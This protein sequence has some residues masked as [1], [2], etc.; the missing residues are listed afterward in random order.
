M[1]T[2]S[3]L[4]TINPK[5]P[6]INKKEP[7]R[8]INQDLTSC[9]FSAMFIG[10]KNS[11]KTYGLCAWIRNYESQ[12]IINSEG[13]SVPI[14]IILF[15]PTAQSQANP[16]YKTLKNLDEE[17]IILQYT[18]AELDSKLESI[19]KDKEDIEDYTLYLK[20]WK[21]FLK[22]DE[23]VNLLTPEELLILSKFDFT[24]PKYLNKPKYYPVAPVVFIILDDLIGSNDCFK[25]GNSYISNL[26]IKHRHYGINLIFTSQNPRSIPNIIR[27]NIDV[28]ALY[29]FANVKMVL[30]KIF[31]EVSNILTEEQFEE[32]YKHATEKPH[33][34]LVI[35]THPKTDRD[36]RLRRN[37]DNVLLV[38]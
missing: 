17:D 30:E 23:N 33:D 21:K 20:T 2:E 14:R 32:L 1:I 12:P 26:T 19:K 18:D 28:Y 29:K 6:P 3:K 10:A 27:N 7:P 31:E 24:D 4:T 25:K 13:K 36:K 15:C 8:S 38:T 11:G 35:D 5:L 16:V 9:Y 37:F 34:C 22:I